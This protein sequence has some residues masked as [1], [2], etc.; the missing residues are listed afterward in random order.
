MGTVGSGAAAGALIGEEKH[1]HDNRKS[2]E[3][4]VTGTTTAS[5]GGPTYGGPHD[6]YNAPTG[7]HV[8]DHSHHTGTAPELTGSNNAYQPYRQGPEM[9]GAGH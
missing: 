2:Y 6:R 9:S 3:T 4:G 7:P 1:R 8:N 5:P